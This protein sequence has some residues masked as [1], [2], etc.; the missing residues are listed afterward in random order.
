MKM[1]QTADARKK[2]FRDFLI[3]QNAQGES[4]SNLCKAALTLEFLLVKIIT[5]LVP[6]SR[7]RWD[8]SQE[9]PS[10][11][12]DYHYYYFPFNPKAQEPG[13]VFEAD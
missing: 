13:A 4:E 8:H 6:L 10:W 2:C 5:L 9:N 3:Q 7:S 11:R 12:N 1:T